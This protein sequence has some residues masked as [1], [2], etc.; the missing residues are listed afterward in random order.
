MARGYVKIKIEDAKNP[1]EGS[2]PLQTTPKLLL[3]GKPGH[4]KMSI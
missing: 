3:K 2:E 1:C 4:D